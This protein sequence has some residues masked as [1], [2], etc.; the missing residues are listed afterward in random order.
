[1]RTIRPARRRED[2]EDLALERLAA[3]L[4]DARAA[5]AQHDLLAAA[6]ELE[7]VHLAALLEPPAKVSTTCSRPWHTQPSSDTCQATSGSS[8]AAAASTSPRRSAPKK[9]IT[10]V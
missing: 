10:T 6:G 8:S 5:G 2:V 9:S 4:A 1:M 7:R 3:H